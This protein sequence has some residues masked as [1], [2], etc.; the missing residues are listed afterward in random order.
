MRWRVSRPS[1][2]MGRWLN[3]QCGEQMRLPR[4]ALAGVPARSTR[5]STLTAHP[6]RGE[7][8]RGIRGKQP[9]GDHVVFRAGHPHTKLPSTERFGSTISMRMSVLGRKVI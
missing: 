7:F 5:D 8:L 4:V 2:G 6:L 9:A 3:W 1:L